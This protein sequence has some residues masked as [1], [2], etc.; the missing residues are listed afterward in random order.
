MATNCWMVLRFR[1]RPVEIEA[2]R[3]ESADAAAVSEF[4]GLGDLTV[5]GEQLMTPTQQGLLAAAPGD[6]IVCGVQ[7]EC[8]PVKRDIF[9]AT[10]EPAN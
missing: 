5:D 4:V 6:W 9:V 3:Y 7:G 8:Y 10:C 2:L 1:K